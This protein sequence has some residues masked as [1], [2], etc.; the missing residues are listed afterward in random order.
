MDCINAP[1]SK[2]TSDRPKYKSTHAASNT[3]TFNHLFSSEPLP[4]SNPFLFACHLSPNENDP[5]GVAITGPSS[6]AS[7][8]FKQLPSIK[9]GPPPKKREEIRKCNQNT[10][11]KNQLTRESCNST[12]KEGRS[13]SLNLAPCWLMSKAEKHILGSCQA[14]G[15]LV[16]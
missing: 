3:S 4:P 7:R 8:C 10:G 9:T 13:Y 6:R 15:H 5:N 16:L 1:P 11:M 12:S 14:T 2:Y